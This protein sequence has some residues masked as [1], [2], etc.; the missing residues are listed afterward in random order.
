MNRIV[1][2]SIALSYLMVVAGCQSPR[3]VVEGESG[4]KYP[5]FSEVE[6]LHGHVCPGSAMGYRMACSALDRIEE[7]GIGSR[8]LMAIVENNKCGTDSLQCVTGCT[9]GKGKVLF[10]DHGKSVYTLF[11]S[12]TRKG[13]RVVFFGDRIPANVREDRD[14]FMRWILE[15]PEE[16][17]LRFSEVTIDRPLPERTRESVSCA[18]CGE[19]VNTNR[20]RESG[21]RQLCIPCAESNR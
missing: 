12:K 18:V 14:V 5:P 6:R 7:M 2:P 9:F 21:G 4:A 11:S 3:N 1:L 20:V 13:V 10:D 16:S 8:E 19:G 15:A 17:I